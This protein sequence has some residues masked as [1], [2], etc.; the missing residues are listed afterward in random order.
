LVL[1]LANPSYF[2]ITSDGNLL[3]KT[4]QS[5]PN[6]IF[7]AKVNT[8][9]SALE[10]ATM[11]GGTGLDTPSGI[12]VDAGGDAFLTGN[13]YSTDFPATSGVVQ[14][15]NKGAA[16]YSGQAFLSKLALAG[17]TDDHFLTQ[18]TL[19]VSAAS[20]T[21]GTP[22]T[23]T[24]TTA[25]AAADVATGNIVF[26]A[27][28]SSPEP[29]PATSVAL[30]AKG[31]AAL[32][33]STLA[34]G[35]YTLYATYA[36]DSAH[37]SSNSSVQANGTV[38]FYVA[39]AASQIS[40]KFGFGPTVYGD[41][42]GY[43]V[44]ALVTDSV[45]DPVS[46]VLVT[47]SAGSYLK[48]S[49]AAVAT[50]ANGIAEV[51]V[52]LLK[53]GTFTMYASASGIQNAAA[54]RAVVAPAPLTVTLQGS[55]RLYGAANPT[56]LY[57]VQGLVGSDT[58]TVTPQTTATL[59]SPVGTYPISATVSGP[60][61]TNYI[62]TV[63]GGILTI[64]KAPLYISARNAATF[65]GQTPAPPTAYQITGFVNGDTASVVSGAPVLTT[66]VTSTTPVGFYPI[67][68]QAGTLAAANYYFDN[69]SNGE[70]AEGVYKAPLTILPSSFSI[71]VG[72]PLP[73]FTYTITGFVNSDTQA[74]ATS[75]APVLS[76]T[77]PSTSKPGRYYIVGGV[78]SLTAHNYYFTNPG[79]ATNGILTI[80]K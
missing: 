30:D 46:G 63:V 61:A 8:T 74:S 38:S 66:T 53:A 12:T 29:F 69:F 59:T 35:H 51:A 27:A 9:G 32:T 75:G 55:Y 6:G 15:V 20:V 22:I 1:G 45:G 7:L 19:T 14:G 73:T 2:S 50:D 70:G 49:P 76:T 21:H 43:A 10:Y 4:T 57:T 67:G 16:R 64:R 40:W 77:A 39:G 71:H 37:L 62:A 56:F 47:F 25:S 26:T 33:T 60:L 23:I 28:P 5:R 17:E 41:R 52:T 18:L 58:V 44:D 42:G 36:G 72:D 3:Q 48:F 11:F 34:P 80:T 54:F 78:G 13:T 79:P 68:V 24:A 31:V 65:Y